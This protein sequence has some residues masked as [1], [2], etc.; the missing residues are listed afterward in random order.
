M[1]LAPGTRLGPY[2]I[3]AAIGAGGMGEVYRAKDTRLDRTVAI[4]V[5]PAHVSQDPERKARFER[6]AKTIAS[7]DHP[8]ICVLHDVGHQDGIDYLVMEYLEG[9][10]LVERLAK[11][12]LP[13][14]QVVRYGAEIANALARAHRAHVVHRDLK[15]ANILLTRTGA[16]LLDFGLARSEAPVTPPPAL[17]SHSPT[18]TRG[19][20]AEGTLLGTF[21]YMSPEQL[22]GKEADH[23]ADIWALGCVLYEMAAGRRAFQGRSSASL[24]AAIMHTEP[25]PLSTLQP[26][27]PPLLDGL[28]RKCLAKDPDE[29]WQSSGDV[30]EALRWIAPAAPAVEVQ[31]RRIS[32]L[33]AG[34]LAVVGV[35]LGV[36]GFWQGRRTAPVPA[37]PVEFRDITFSGQDN[38]PA[39]SP[40][41]HLVAF[42][43]NRDGRHRIWVKEL[44]GGNEVALTEG[45]NDHVPRFSPDGSMILFT[46]GLPPH[47]A[48]WKVATLGGEARKLVDDA[49]GGD[50]S[51]DGRIVYM[52]VKTEDNRTLRNLE[53]ANADGSGS[54]EIVPFREGL[55]RTPRWSPD[56][57]TIAYTDGRSLFLVGSDGGNARS[58]PAPPFWGFVGSPA[59]SGD[60][61]EVL[62]PQAATDP[63][64]GRGS[65]VIRQNLITAAAEPIL[66]LTHD[67]EFL[68]ILGPGRLVF[69]TQ[70]ASSNLGALQLQTGALKLADRWLTRGSGINLQPTYSPDGE[71]VLFTSN[72]SANLDL[73]EISARSG[74]LRRITDDPGTDWDPGFTP[75]GKNILFTSNRSGNYEIWIADAD[76]SNARRVTRDD[77]DAENATATPDGWIAYV[78][79]NPS[80][81]GLWKIRRDGSRAARLAESRVVTPEVSPDGRYVAYSDGEGLVFVRIEDGARVPF[82]LRARGASHPRWMQEGRAVAFVGLDEKTLTQEV[83]VQDFVPGRDTLKTRRKLTGLVDDMQVHSFGISPDGSRMVIAYEQGGFNLM[84][85]ERVPGVLPPVRMK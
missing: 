39:A 7:L 69:G 20:T 27:T 9:E 18:G 85:A 36:L 8:H 70:R 34:A 23:R 11:G 6:E 75:D 57:R 40:D 71:W 64:L 77:V 25:V 1:T 17:D 2:E 43:S 26:V 51:P 55:M 53:R 4:K 12:P 52:R 30:A 60:G 49:Q 61:H 47:S 16:K 19:L 42:V 46:R 41:G 79:F 13:V 66:S 45:P 68:D 84:T 3:L 37:E 10:T 50:W 83:Y 21:P 29:R 22:E 82:D 28:V 33:W 62:Y 80:K 54:H 31:V 58:F 14:D 74:A 56:G 81:R 48:L 65:R 32:P 63:F 73:W 78:S 5:L 44:A 38:M 76:G 15:P 24:I 72:R 59:W 67:V 35:S